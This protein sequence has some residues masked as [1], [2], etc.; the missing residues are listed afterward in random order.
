MHSGFLC[1]KAAVLGEPIK[2]RPCI[3]YCH[4]PGWTEKKKNKYFSSVQSFPREN[5]LHGFNA[6]TQQQNIINEICGSLLHSRKRLF[7]KGTRLTACRYPIS[8]MA[9]LFIYHLQHTGRWEPNLE[10][11]VYLKSVTTAPLIFNSPA[12]PPA[13]HF[14]KQHTHYSGVAVCGRHPT[15]ACFYCLP[16]IVT[17]DLLTHRGWSS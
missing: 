2:D 11:D 13:Q 14:P 1:N 4:L 7:C 15:H 8:F 16:A 12:R 17:R 5:S 9:F 6:S 10:S 3:I